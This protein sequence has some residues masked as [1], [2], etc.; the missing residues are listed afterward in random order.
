[1]VLGTTQISTP[2]RLGKVSSCGFKGRGDDAAF[3]PFSLK[4]SEAL[5]RYGSC[6]PPCFSQD[7]V[8]LRP[9]HKLTSCAR[10]VLTGPTWG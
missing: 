10:S 1:M 2:P 6:F 9:T 3:P 4:P 7:P 8:S 5:K